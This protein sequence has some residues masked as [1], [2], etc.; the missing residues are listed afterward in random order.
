MG[1][2]GKKVLITG[3][4]TGIGREIALAFARE[5]ASVAVNY[6]VNPSEAERVIQEINRLGGKG[7]KVQAD[8]SDFSQTQ[9]MAAE[10]KKQ[11]GSLDV[12]VNN[13]GIALDSIL[14]KMEQRV[15]EKVIAVN[16]TGVFNTT[17]SCLPLLSKGGRVISISSIV[18]MHGNFGQCNYAASK[19]GIIGFTKSLAKELGDDGIT[20]NAVAPGF[21]DTRMTKKL[22]K[23]VREMLMQLLSLKRMGQPKDVANAVLFLASDKASYI[24]G[25]VLEVAGGLFT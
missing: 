16:L 21:I 17:R 24:T 1:F 7:I 9:G 19:A 23:P 14:G 13:A 20:V 2:E 25:H 18:G 3:A 4:A 12:V 5:G 6:L 15:W 22:P 11:F 10:I 8:V